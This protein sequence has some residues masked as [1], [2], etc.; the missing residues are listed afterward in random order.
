MVS[1][2]KQIQHN[3]TGQAGEQQTPWQQAQADQQ[4]ADEQQIHNAQDTPSYSPPSFLSHGVIN[5]TNNL[6][7]RNAPA[8]RGTILR[9]SSFGEF[10]SIYG[11]SG[12]GKIENGVL[13]L[14]Y[15]VS[16]D[17]EW[18]NA[19]Y[20]RTFP[21]YIGSVEKN[22]QFEEDGHFYNMVKIEIQGHKIVEGKMELYVVTKG[23]R[24][25]VNYSGF[26]DVLEEYTFDRFNVKLFDSTYNNLVSY[27]EEIRTIGSNADWYDEGKVKRYSI[28]IKDWDRTV[29]QNV[30][31]EINSDDINLTGI[32]VGSKADDIAVQFDHDIAD[33][34]DD[35]R[36]IFT[37][38]WTRNW[39]EDEPSRLEFVILEG[40]I[41]QIIYSVARRK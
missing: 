1:C 9:Q 40:K 28:E 12:S 26:V 14:W 5:I 7:I 15:K 13:D 23:G 20:L 34:W 32:R 18:I 37:G 10:F 4:Q 21:F 22:K 19:L 3:D 33:V 31:I 2:D 39:I 35:Y 29:G 25:P 30:Y 41:K 27:I 16:P 17:E 6:N 36:I 38:N 8:L 11:Q 24:S